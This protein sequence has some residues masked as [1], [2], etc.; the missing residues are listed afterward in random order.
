MPL[1]RAD[2]L[3][4]VVMDSLALFFLSLLSMAL[5]YETK[6]SSEF[7]TMNE[8]FIETEVGVSNSPLT[9]VVSLAPIVT[10]SPFRAFAAEDLL[11]VLRSLMEPPKRFGE[12]SVF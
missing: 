6:E 11:R 8:F 2:L 10:V 7:L 5:P 9:T 3:A 1:T 12:L 4:T